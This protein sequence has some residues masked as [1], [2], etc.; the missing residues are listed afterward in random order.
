MD[1]HEANSASSTQADYEAAAR[2]FARSALNPLHD[3]AS[4]QE[5]LDSM[6]RLADVTDP[7]NCGGF[8]LFAKSHDGSA[9]MRDAIA[10]ALAARDAA[11]EAEP[12][13][14]E[15]SQRWLAVSEAGM[16]CIDGMRAVERART[17]A[18]AEAI[19][20]GFVINPDGSVSV[21]EGT[22][23]DDETRVRRARHEHR[24][25]QIHG[26]EA[27]LQA[28]TVA[29][30]RERIGADVPGMPWAILE[31]ARG[32]HDLTETFNSC[33]ALPD[34]PFTS[35]MHEIVTYA[36]EANAAVWPYPDEEQSV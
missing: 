25:M 19:A 28:S 31:C 8:K 16:A 10:A 5:L 9:V 12:R 13:R 3:R 21:D 2:R 7:A 15:L 26:Q 27:D 14:L 20:D 23:A 17:E 29:T 4:S 36:K 6:S 30:I 18:E 22:S 24:L 1:D 32:G 33:L 34:S 35:L 11:D